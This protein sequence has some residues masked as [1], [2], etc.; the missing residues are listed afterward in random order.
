MKTTNILVAAGLIVASL[1]MSTAADAQ[2]YRGDR[3]DHHDRAGG[4]RHGRDYRY[5]RHDNGRHYGWGNNRRHHR[6]WTEYRHHRQVRV[7]R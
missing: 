6:C 5:G 2:Q 3:Y 1:G 4:D 7:C